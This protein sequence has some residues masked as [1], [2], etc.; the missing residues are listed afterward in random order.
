[1]NLK[2]IFSILVIVAMITTYAQA[3]KVQTGKALI[4]NTTS[5]AEVDRIKE[6][7]KDADPSTY[8]LTI[9]TDVKGKPKTTTLGSAPVSEVNKIKGATKLGSARG[10]YTASDVVVIVKV[11]TSG[12]EL[13]D[14]IL[15]Q[16]DAKLSKSAVVDFN[17]QVDKSNQ[18]KVSKVGN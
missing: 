18:L 13:R 1:M 14:N 6:A 16:M 11:I 9:T 3:Q 2:P 8:R 5:K 12:Y 17:Y 4:I 10:G 15:K 7:L